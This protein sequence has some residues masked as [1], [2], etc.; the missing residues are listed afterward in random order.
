MDKRNCKY[1]KIRSLANDEVPAIVVESPSYD[2]LPYADEQMDNPEGGDKLGTMQ[3][4]ITCED[5]KGTQKRRLE[6]KNSISMPN[7]DDLKVFSDNLQ[8]VSIFHKYYTI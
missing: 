6:R 8:E 3:D 5:E 2:S 1:Q 7:L 4:R